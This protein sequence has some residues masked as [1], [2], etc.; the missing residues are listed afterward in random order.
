MPLLLPARIMHAYACTPPPFM[1]RWSTLDIYYTEREPRGILWMRNLLLTADRV[2]R[3]RR[4]LRSGLAVVGGHNEV[5]A[6]LNR[7]SM[8]RVNICVYIY[9]Q[10]ISTR[11]GRCTYS[12]AK[13]ALSLHVFHSSFPKSPDSIPPC[14][15]LAHF[16][17]R[18]RSFISIEYHLW[19]CFQR[20][21]CSHC[22]FFNISF[23]QRSSDF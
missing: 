14:R 2:A 10:R 20:Y 9:A 1:R 18:A 8:L 23:L 7:G 17:K 5:H 3:R 13:C 4:P 11:S 16:E 6:L 21:C 19:C 22:G 15:Y 12:N